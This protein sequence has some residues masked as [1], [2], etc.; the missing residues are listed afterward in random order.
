[1]PPHA[2]E[3]TLSFDELR[4]WFEARLSQSFSIQ[5]VAAGQ[6]VA[7]LTGPIDTVMRFRAGSLHGFFVEGAADAW[8]FDLVEAE[9][10]SAALWPIPGIPDALDFKQLKITM[11]GYLLMID[12]EPEDD[13]PDEQE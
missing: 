8:S 5:V 2:H 12:R 11:R 1:L 9:F 3:T 7:F 10:L 4:E 13:W 6:I